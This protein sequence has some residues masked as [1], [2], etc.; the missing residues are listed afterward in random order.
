MR[1]S[2]LDLRRHMR[3]IL[4]ALDQNEPVTLTYRGNEKATIIP[5]KHAVDFDFK[6]H[7]TFGIWS[8]EKDMEDV[9]SFVRQLRKG[10]FNAL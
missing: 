2:I 9:T 3:E 5:K 6:K 1:A 10:R 4:K 8:D 7:P